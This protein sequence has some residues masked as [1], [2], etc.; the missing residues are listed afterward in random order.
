VD[1][2]W[3]QWGQW[4]D[5]STT[6]D[7]GVKIRQRTCSD[8]I[9]QQNGKP[10]NGS[11]EDSEQCILSYCPGMSANVYI[12]VCTIYIQHRRHDT[13]LADVQDFILHIAS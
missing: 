5:C 7:Y 9:P 4:S 2:G 11:D 12:L 6:C 10:C 8:P 1:G 13:Q 3:S